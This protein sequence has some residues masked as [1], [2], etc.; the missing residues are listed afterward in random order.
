MRAP[1][2]FPVLA[3]LGLIVMALGLVADTLEHTLLLDA[4]PRLAGFS[5]AQHV[6]HLVVLVGMVLV[7]AGVVADG[8]RIARGRVPRP[9]RSRSDAVR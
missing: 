8:V 4:G 3:R 9:E 2:P 6:A 1:R 5:A 7:L